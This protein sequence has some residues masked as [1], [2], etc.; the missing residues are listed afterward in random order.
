[1]DIRFVP[2]YG[3]DHEPEVHL[4]LTALRF[5]SVVMASSLE[6]LANLRLAYQTQGSVPS[7]FKLSNLLW[8]FKSKIL[9]IPKTEYMVYWASQESPT[10]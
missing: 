1:M 8:S 4:Q 3:I 10:M 2:Y 5:M 7:S 9:R 6:A